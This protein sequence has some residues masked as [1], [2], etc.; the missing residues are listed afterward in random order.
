MDEKEKERLTNGQGAILSDTGRWW[1]VSREA[2]KYKAQA[3]C[4]RELD[5]S[6]TISTGDE[7]KP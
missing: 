7:Q 3:A 6:S 2:G 4:P 5:V 1:R